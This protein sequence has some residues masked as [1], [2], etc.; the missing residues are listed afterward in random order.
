MP[1]R[2]YAQFIYFCSPSGTNSQS[3]WEVGH[4]RVASGF[5]RRPDLTRLVFQEPRVATVLS[6]VQVLS[7]KHSLVSHMSSS[8]YSIQVLF[9]Q[10]PIMLRLATGVISSETSKSQKLE[11]P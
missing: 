11:V 6:I 1:K 5:L 2:L 8:I 4:L 3:Y 9:I 7:R 10:H